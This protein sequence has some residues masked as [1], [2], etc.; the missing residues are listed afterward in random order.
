MRSLNRW[1]LAALRVVLLKLI[2]Q[3]TGGVILMPGQ[4]PVDRVHSRARDG[5][6]PDWR[7]TMQDL[8]IERTNDRALRFTGTLVAD[9]RFTDSLDECVLIYRTVE[10]RYVRVRELRA[11]RGYGVLVVMA[12][13]ADT[14]DALLTLLR[15]SGR[16][17]TCAGAKAWR[18]ACNNDS[19]LAAIEFEDADYHSPIPASD[20]PPAVEEQPRFEPEEPT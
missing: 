7:T 9:A 17:M 10:G 2:A 19:A 5:S 3:H 16:A 4:T 13:V 15:Y 8:V 20:C 11:P 14:P 12:E 6:P 18:T 1:H